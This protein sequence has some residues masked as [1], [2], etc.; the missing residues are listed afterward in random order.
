MVSLAVFAC[1][2]AFGDQLSKQQIDKAVAYAEAN[3]SQAL[4]IAQ[5]GKIVCERYF[6]GFERDSRHLLASGSKTFL[7]LTAVAAVDDGKIKLDDLATKYFPEWKGDGLKSQIMLRQLMTMSSGVEA[8]KFSE[9]RR[10]EPGWQELLSKPMEA[11][12]GTK[13]HYGPVHINL[14][15][16]AIERALKTESFESYLDRKILKP[17]GIRVDWQMRYQDGHPQVA[18]GAFMNANDWIKLGEMLRQKGVYNGKRILSERAV[19]TLVQ[20]SQ[21]NA[22][23]GLTCWL[24]PDGE[25][26]MSNSDTRA[27]PSWVPT[28]FFMA[29]GMGKQ[30]LYIIPSR[31]IVAVRFGKGLS[32]RYKD[33]GVLEPLLNRS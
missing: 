13:Y 22:N 10:G 33:N 2:I 12:P 29:A 23:Y 17:I 30:R 4:I 15:A 9:N 19:A 7:G 31:G 26:V 25:K 20:P 21:T 8:G 14:G 11:E 27:L 5:N 3:Q 6:N 1:G 32:V 16:F 28:D 24:V 18:G